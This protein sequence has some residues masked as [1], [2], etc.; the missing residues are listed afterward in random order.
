MAGERILVVD[1][2][3][4]ILDILGVLLSG[5]GYEVRTTADPCR[6][7][8]LAAEIRPDLAIL[9]VAMPVLDGFQLASR[10]RSDPVL[11]DLPLVFLTA[12]DAA[13]DLGRARELRAAAYVEKPFQKEA[14]L[15]LLE[16]IFLRDA[17]GGPMCRG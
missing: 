8:P 10:I 14:L 3:P 5:A 12:R 17:K 11:A 15:G 16:Q 9:D 6:A 2:D 7:L 1:D 13:T 4:K